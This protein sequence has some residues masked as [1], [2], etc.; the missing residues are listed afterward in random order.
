LA[1]ID[2]AAIAA[3]FVSPSRSHGAVVRRTELEAVDER[4]VGA[5]TRPD[6]ARKPAQVGAMEAVAIDHAG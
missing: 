3:L 2:A 5:L 6:A 4:D 1:T